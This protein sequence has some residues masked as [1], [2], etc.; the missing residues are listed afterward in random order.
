VWRAGVLTRFWS[1]LDRY[2]G[3]V[4]AAFAGH[5][6]MDEFRLPTVGGFVHVTPAVSPLFGNNPGFAVF[7]YAPASGELADV[8]TYYLDL[9]ANAAKGRGAEGAE[10]WAQ[11]YDFRQAYA[12]PAI[13][14]SALAAVQRAIACDA[15]VRDRYMTFYPVSSAASSTDLAHWQAYWCAAQAFTPESF[16]DCYCPAAPGR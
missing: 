6:H 10:R 11:E 4:K 9:A 16:A 14:G 8:R 7:S 1:I 12:Q 3:V 13:D 15:A 5:T 2:P